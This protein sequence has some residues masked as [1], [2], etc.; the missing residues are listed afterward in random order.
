[1]K[2]H[3]TLNLLVLACAAAFNAGDVP[4]ANPEETER[5]GKEGKI[6][7]T[8]SEAPASERCRRSQA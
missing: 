7:P 4:A 2:T 8:R 3:P 1:V 5:K 6:V